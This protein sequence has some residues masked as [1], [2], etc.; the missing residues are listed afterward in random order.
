MLKRPRTVRPSVSREEYLLRNMM[1]AFPGGEWVD[2]TPEEEAEVAEAPGCE[3]GGRG[4]ESLTPLSVALIG[5]QKYDAESV[6]AY[7]A[8]L[9]A[10]T[11]VYVGAGRGV[12][13][14]LRKAED[15]PVQ[16]QV[17]DLEP[18]RYGKK[19]RDV[20]VAQVLIQDITSPVVLV[21]AG[22]RVKQAR[23]W[24]KTVNDHRDE[25]NQRQVVVL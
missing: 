18:D 11:T 6:Q 16:V 7:L 19:A 2:S 22:E 4:F 12:E 9:P 13:S 14:D 10:G 25:E 20:N 24:L 21:G 23:S 1:R 5:G 8:S 17:V 3:P 15:C